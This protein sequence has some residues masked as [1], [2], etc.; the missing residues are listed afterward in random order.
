M[1][2]FQSAS[3]SCGVK[4]IGDE[5]SETGSHANGDDIGRRQ[6]IE[7]KLREVVEIINENRK[8]H[9]DMMAKFKKA[10][11]NKACSDDIL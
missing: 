8:Q 3:L 4:Q 2:S 6:V 9:T 5:V 11:E 1:H 7:A 10:L